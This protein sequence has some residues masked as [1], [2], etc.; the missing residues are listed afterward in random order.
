[1]YAQRDVGILGGVGRGA[2]DIDLV[3]ADLLGAL[4]AQVFVGDGVEAEVA[5]AQLAEV[6]ALVGLDDV[7]LQHG[8]V[9]DAGQRDAVVGEDVLVVLG[10]L[11]HFLAVDRFQPG[12]QPGQ[13]FCARQLVGDAGGGVGERDVAGFADLD[14]QRDADDAGGEGVEAGGFGIEGGQFGGFDPGQPDIELRPGEYGFVADLGRCRVAQ[15][16]QGRLRLSPESLAGLSR[17]LS[18]VLNS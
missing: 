16:Q 3:E 14:R 15:R 7:A 2:F 9:R 12:F 5:G 10:V 6:V 8:V 18:Q 1:M 4:A 17:S 13:H 11:Q